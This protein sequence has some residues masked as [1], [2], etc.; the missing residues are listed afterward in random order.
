MFWSKFMETDIFLECFDG[1][2]FSNV[3]KNPIN[4]KRSAINS[5]GKILIFFLQSGDFIMCFIVV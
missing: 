5:C 1:L 3:K 2:P 4:F